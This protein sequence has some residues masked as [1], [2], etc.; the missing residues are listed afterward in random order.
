MGQMEGF[1]SSGLI[2][3]DL[4][5]PEWYLFFLLYGKINSCSDRKQLRRR[6]KW[7]RRGTLSIISH[8]HDCDALDCCSVDC[9]VV[10]GAEQSNGSSM[11]EAKDENKWQRRSNSSVFSS[12]RAQSI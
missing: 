7:D 3:A 5:S 8:L 2:C 6:N 11:M 9:R 12:E 1:T 4:S 10:A